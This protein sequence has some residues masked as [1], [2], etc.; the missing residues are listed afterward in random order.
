MALLAAPRLP[1]RAASL[2]SELLPAQ[3]SLL[4]LI[5]SPRSPRPPPPMGDDSLRQSSFM[6]TK[7]RGAFVAVVSASLWGS[8]GCCGQGGCVGSCA[9]E[10]VVLT[11]AGRV[12]SHAQVD[13]E[14]TRTVADTASPRRWNSAHSK[15]GCSPRA[16]V[17]RTTGLKTVPKVMPSIDDVS[18]FLVAND[19]AQHVPAFRTNKVDGRVLLKL[20]DDHLK[21]LGMR[22]LAHRQ[23]LV[24]HRKLWFDQLKQDHGDTRAVPRRPTVA[25]LDKQV[26]RAEAKVRDLTRQIDREDAKLSPSKS[27]LERLYAEVDKVESRTA[28]VSANARIEHQMSSSLPPDPSDS[29]DVTL[30]ASW[31]RRWNSFNSSGWNFLMERS[32][33]DFQPG[34]DGALPPLPRP[35][36]TLVQVPGGVAFREKWAVEMGKENESMRLDSIARGDKVEQERF[37]QAMHITTMM[38]RAFRAAAYQPGGSNLKHLLRQYDRDNAGTIDA[39]QFLHA[40]RT[41]G[42]ISNRILTDAD[43]MKLFAFLDQEG[44]NEITA[45]QFTDFLSRAPGSPR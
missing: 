41:H 35:E 20:T 18:D 7:V 14:G 11:D 19:L 33:A 29:V 16:R 27:E 8:L 6:L 13:P 17:R 24:H 4:P 32:T 21:R 43:V 12:Q 36:E 38:H 42:R 44:N 26:K 15:A 45:D 9:L 10:V 22:A 3:D 5:A 25:D 37:Q 34:E 23:T 1:G 28:I 2:S 31:M 30:P 39:R 40:V